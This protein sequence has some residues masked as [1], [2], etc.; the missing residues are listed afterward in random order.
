[1]L[2]KTRGWYAKCTLRLL[3]PT[4]DVQTLLKGASKGTVN[5]H[6]NPIPISH[7][8]GGLVFPGTV[9][10]NASVDFPSLDYDSTDLASLDIA[11]ERQLGGGVVDTYPLGKIA[12]MESNGHVVAIVNFRSSKEASFVEDKEKLIVQATS[13]MYSSLVS[14]NDG[15][16]DPSLQATYA[17]DSSD[18]GLAELALKRSGIVF[19]TVHC[20]DGTCLYTTLAPVEAASL[21]K[22]KQDAQLEMVTDLFAVEMG[23]GAR[24]WSQ[25]AFKIDPKADPDLILAKIKDAAPD[26][27]VR[28]GSNCGVDQ[29]FQV[30]F[31]S[32]NNKKEEA[33]VRK[34]IKANGGTVDATQTFE[35]EQACFGTQGNLISEQGRVALM[36]A[37]I[38]ADTVDCADGICCF[39]TAMPTPNLEETLLTVD[40]VT[41]VS[42]FMSRAPKADTPARGV[43][44]I[45]F[46]KVEEASAEAVLGALTS[47]FGSA[48]AFD[49]QC[50]VY[51]CTVAA[52][53]DTL[54]AQM[55]GM[56]TVLAGVNAVVG[57]PVPATDRIATV[58]F[59]TR[60]GRRGLSAS[61]T[62]SPMAVKYLLINSGVD[63]IDVQCIPEACTFT[64]PESTT[65]LPD[66][67]ALKFNLNS[68]IRSRLKTLRVLGMSS[69]SEDVPT[70]SAA[71]FDASTV[72]DAN[73]A[74]KL[75]LGDA[76]VV[77]TG[78]S[79]STRGV[80]TFTTRHMAPNSN[81]AVR[82]GGM[83]AFDGALVAAAPAMVGTDKYHGSF[84]TADGTTFSTQAATAA[85]FQA[86]LVPTAVV[87]T[88]NKC[89]FETMPHMSKSTVDKLFAKLKGVSSVVN[90][91]GPIVMDRDFFIKQNVINSIAKA[92]GLDASQIEIISI[93][94]DGTVKFNVIDKQ[95]QYRFV[96]TYTGDVAA[97]R[98]TIAGVLK[99]KE[100][101]LDLTVDAV[102][103]II[104]FYSTA[105]LTAEQMSALAA[106]GVAIVEQTLERGISA[107]HATD[108]LVECARDGCGDLATLGALASTS[109]DVEKSEVRVACVVRVSVT[110]EGIEGTGACNRNGE[111]LRKPMQMCA[112]DAVHTPF[113]N[114]VHIIAPSIP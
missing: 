77:A 75:M 5:V 41:T 99:V 101:D 78:V 72:L 66:T 59:D 21:A 36:L 96:A 69:I 26:T 24:Q 103:G 9:S 110:T 63:V 68:D 10:Q 44:T 20:I 114:V 100:S 28:L 64:V 32:A 51:F 54:V 25:F 109:I 38:T 31:F 7:F 93:G 4:G 67:A 52:E 95:E 98:A 58:S 62:A 27:T 106:A 73:D 37:K 97:L 112:P 30:L 3:V 92:T 82:L 57:N 111:N 46:E 91:V 34:L 39:T 105:P 81:M 89:T 74:G 47:A 86:N 45:M 56:Q 90:V 13:M 84:E 40:G 49:L 48:S 104:Y 102:S 79:C 55:A 17:D 108:V 23:V 6:P 11:L 80:C 1:M 35:S 83:T 61:L 71:T 94:A 22:L 65:K 8:Q 70:K 19:D 85:V 113:T 50:T 16:S 14:S 15:S 87:C 12:F 53:M 107:D 76:G 18:K 43:V 60:K 29:C 33:A 88:S 2:C 42:P